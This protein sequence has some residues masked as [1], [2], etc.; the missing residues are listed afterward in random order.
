MDTRAALRALCASAALFIGLAQAAGSPPD[1]A[2]AEAGRAIAKVEEATQHAYDEALAALDA[3]TKQ[4]PGDIGLA[5]SRCRFLQFYGDPEGVRWISGAEDALASCTQQLRERW[6][7]APQV[8]LFEMETLFGEEAAT[9][10]EALLK[11]ADQWPA[12][13]RREL[14]SQTSMGHEFNDNP[15]R[16]G[17]LALMAVRMGDVSRTGAA[18]QYLV[19]QKKLDEAADLL[20]KAAPSENPMDVAGRVKAALALP[21]PKAGLA[22]LRRKPELMEYVD[23]EVAARA[24]LRAGDFASAQRVLKNV[25]IKCEATRSLKFEAAMGARDY[26]GAAKL[27]DLTDRPNF[28]GH[29]SRFATLAMAAPLTLVSPTM[30][31]GLAICLAWLLLLLLAPGVV[32]VPAHY[33]GLARRLKGKVSEP[34]FPAI[35]LKRAWY[36]AAVALI[37][38]MVVLMLVRPEAM[39]DL[40]SGNAAASAQMFR[41][42]LIAEI[43]ALVFVVPALVGMTRRQFLGDRTAL[44]TWWIV[45]LMWGALI[46]L[47]WVLAVVQTWMGVNLETAQ[48]RM[49]AAMV[50]GG[51][52]LGGPMLTLLI[53]ALIGP[54]F[55]EVVFRGLMLGGLSRHISFGW[56]NALQ[57]LGFAAMHDDPPRFLYYFAMGLFGGWLVKRTGSLA[58]TIALHVLNN[59]VAVG[60][61]L[62]VG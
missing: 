62:G 52:E 26:A 61:L 40:F 49:V 56:A 36:G 28:A 54:V 38:P 21:D 58:P 35:G 6:P 13:P 60:V 22:E 34:M 59:A 55:E 3:A 44:R 15:E 14:L 29:L 45:L 33:R 53:L 8:A 46:A 4:A 1:F 42:F 2:A 20:A 11:V 37:V 18:A 9:R 19:N 23:H 32:L 27:V 47:G 41:A 57:A 5:V 16:A 30:L 43:T 48:T 7:N 24:Y 12:P 51:E 31:P 39:A 50:E 17:E 25:C 10:G